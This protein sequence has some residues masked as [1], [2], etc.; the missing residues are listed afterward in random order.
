MILPSLRSVNPSN[1]LRPCCEVV[2]PLL[3]FDI[4]GRN[5]TALKQRTNRYMTGPDDNASIGHVDMH[6]RHSSLERLNADH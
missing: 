3:R 5:K 1:C 4:T 2:V 6:K